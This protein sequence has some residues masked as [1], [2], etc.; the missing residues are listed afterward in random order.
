MA[1]RNPSSKKS[2]AQATGSKASSVAG[3][4][5]RE[6]QGTPRSVLN[7]DSEKLKPRFCSAY[8]YPI[9]ELSHRSSNPTFRMP[10][11]VDEYT[12]SMFMFISSKHN[13]FR[14]AHLSLPSLSAWQ[15]WKD[16]R[17][18]RMNPGVNPLSSTWQQATAL[19]GRSRVN[20]D[21]SPANL[22]ILLSFF[23]DID[24]MQGTAGHLRL[25]A[26]A[27]IKGSNFK[28]LLVGGQVASKRLWI[29]DSPSG[30]IIPSGWRNK[31]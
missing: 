17:W 23:L 15:T 14:S 18:Q 16:G 13:S 26:V 2:Y 27:L 10:W 31:R 29:P 4:D 7:E 8:G 21:H 1:S 28:L 5:R 24:S 19:E 25:T 30:G 12:M 20:N 9:L 11:K 3:S 22:T 6:A